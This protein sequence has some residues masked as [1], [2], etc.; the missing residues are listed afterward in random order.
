MKLQ[1]KILPIL[2]IIASLW[3]AS[4]TDKEYTHETLAT[5]ELGINQYST[6]PPG[7]SAVLPREYPGAPPF[8]PHSLSGLTITK[9]KNPCLTCHVQGVSFGPDHTATKIPESHY[10]D[11]PTGNKSQDIQPIRYNC[12]ICHIPQSAETHPLE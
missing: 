12:V 2:L 11:I 1:Y 8:V 3:L 9:D 5:G 6:Q 4:C 7:Q 10:I